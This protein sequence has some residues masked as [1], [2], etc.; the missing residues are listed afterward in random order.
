MC[1]WDMTVVRGYR[2]SGRL[3]P[4]IIQTCWS[5]RYVNN[6]VT[7]QGTFRNG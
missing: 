2:T 3:A 4:Q 6:G 7:F 5:P 1:G